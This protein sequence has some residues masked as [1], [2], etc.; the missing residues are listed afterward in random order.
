M[1]SCLSYAYL[2]NEPQD[3]F[4]SFVHL[5][6]ECFEFYWEFFVNMLAH[7]HW[8]YDIAY[9]TWPQTSSVPQI[10]VNGQKVP[11]G[12]ALPCGILQLY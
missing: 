12:L 8:V 9:V 7:Q 6:D 5:I 10:W 2:V 1:P 11:L 4:Y 3:L